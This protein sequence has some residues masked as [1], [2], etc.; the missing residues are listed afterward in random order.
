[1][2]FGKRSSCN[3]L[4]LTLNDSPI[5][6]EEEWKYLGTTI[7]AGTELNFVARPD[8]AAFF[9]A[10]NSV[11]NSMPDAHE[12]ILITLLYCNCVPILTYACSVKEYSAAEMSSCNTAI[13]NAL[14]KVFG[15]SRWESIRTLREIFGMKSIYDIFKAA[16]DS[17]IRSCRSHSNPVITHIMSELNL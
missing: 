17:F 10:T 1:M 9:R 8:I 4:P 6:F 7:K 16:Q 11:L 15:F 5:D 13:N 2:V 12:H 14:R 3:V